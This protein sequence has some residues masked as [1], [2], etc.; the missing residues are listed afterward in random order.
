MAGALVAPVPLYRQTVHVELPQP[1][2][3]VTS[4]QQ[5]EERR[6]GALE[7]LHRQVGRVLTGHRQDLCTEQSPC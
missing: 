7:T 1:T 2:G 4:E 3:G 5:V 6:H